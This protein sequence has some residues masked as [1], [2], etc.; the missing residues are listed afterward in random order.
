LLHVDVKFLGAGLDRLIE[1]GS[2]PDHIIGREPHFF[3][4]GVSHSSL[5]PFAT[6]RRVINHPR[7]V[8]RVARCDGE[9][10]VCQRFAGSALFLRIGRC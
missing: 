5:E 2:D 9:F 10:A 1:R 7:I 6:F 3:G 8:G 4:D